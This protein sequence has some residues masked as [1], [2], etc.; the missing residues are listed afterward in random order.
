MLNMES[1]QVDYALVVTVGIS[2]ETGTGSNSKWYM[3]PHSS[4]FINSCVRK[5]GKLIGKYLH[6]FGRSGQRSL[7]FWT[8]SAANSLPV[9]LEL[10]TGSS[11]QINQL[12]QIK[13][14]LKIR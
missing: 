13:I 1:A 4:G 14:A 5:A 7:L 10:A 3:N 8:G 12:T 2:T 9:G 6:C 11:A